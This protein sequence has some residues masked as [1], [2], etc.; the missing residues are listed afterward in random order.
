MA[1]MIDKAPQVLQEMAVRGHKAAAR[2][3]GRHSAE[4]LLL[5]LLDL[6]CIF[7]SFYAVFLI[8][9]EL[10]ALLRFPP[11]LIPNGLFSRPQFG[12]HLAVALAMGAFLIVLAHKNGLYSAV[13]GT[14]FLRE[15]QKLFN[16]LFATLG[17]GI[18]LSFLFGRFVIS[19]LVL[20][21]FV[22]L[23]LPTLAGW[24][25]VRHKWAERTFARNGHPRR[26]LIVGAGKVG[27]YLENL[28]KNSP[29]LGLRP[30]GFLDDWKSPA[31]GPQGNGSR[32]PILGGV[33][34]FASVVFEL[35]V[36]DV[37]ITIP[38]ERGKLAHIVHEAGEMGIAVHVVPEM[39]DLLV[40][41]VA[42]ENIG[43]LP[44]LRLFHARFN[45]GERFLKRLEDILA[46]SLLLLVFAPV[47]AV[48][49]IAVALDSKGPVIYRQKR[50]G[51]GGRPF[52]LLKFRSMSAGADDSRHRTAAEKW[53]HS[54]DPIDER[55]G[56]YKIVGD[57]R[58]TRVGKIIRKYS[59]DELP[60]LWN[61][62]RGEMSLV[63]PRPPIPYEFVQYEEHQKKRLLI[64]PGITGLWQVSGWHKLSF[65]EMVLLDLRYIN[66]WSIW[67]DMWIIGKTVPLV[68]LGRGA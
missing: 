63:G 49:A 7:L 45:A 3:A 53:L 10:P 5:V 66:E 4:G 59:L 35:E 46:A 65:E 44:V 15:F 29:S 18:L 48:I 2:P 30:V 23:L 37:F 58:L 40:R 20:F 17:F 14:W 22:L 57:S 36:D 6:L 33:A 28:L 27:R 62:L 47:M 39:F 19:R 61:V 68:L 56:R 25:L 64:K 38:S 31:S 9:F 52:E 51:L 41:E 60:Q 24:R 1:G 67:L 34:D 12:D 42:F 13:H 8:R 21:G 43:A 54:S 16:T 55:S 11:Q 32:G 50:H 26:V